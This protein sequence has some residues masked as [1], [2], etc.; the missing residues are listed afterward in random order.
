M[1]AFSDY[2][3]PSICIFKNFISN[4]CEWLLQVQKGYS[5]LIYKFIL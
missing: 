1:N 4:R 2:W 3:D 5:I